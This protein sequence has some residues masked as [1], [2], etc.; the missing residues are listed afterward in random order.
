MRLTI[1]L[2]CSFLTAAYGAE[3]HRITIAQLKVTRDVSTNLAAMKKAFAQAGEENAQWIVFPEAML[4]G[5]YGGFDQ[6]EVAKAFADC[7]KLCQQHQ[8]TGLIGTC[9]KANGKTFNQ[10]RIVGPDGKLIGAYA[11]RCLTYGDAKWAEPGTTA[12]VFKAG[13]LKFGTLICNDL[14]GTPGFTDGPNPHLTLKQKKAGAQ[15]IFQSIHSGSSMKYREY[16]ESNLHLRA[17]EAGF[18]IV[19][20]NAFSPPAINAA[21]GVVGTKFEY[22]VQLPRDRESIQTVE[23]NLNTNRR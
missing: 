19:T 17:A 2:L 9:W 11:K 20:C 4:S 14:W 22:L 6:T 8:L 7:Q 12:L 13:G 23:V 21:S 15:L 16:H 18:P 1:L 10:V 3:T 5:Y